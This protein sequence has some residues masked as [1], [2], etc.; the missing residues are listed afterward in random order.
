MS[1]RTSL[2]IC[3]KL[4]DRLRDPRLCLRRTLLR[5][6]M[7]DA[8]A[9]FIECAPT[10]SLSG[11]FSV[12]T[13]LHRQLRSSQT[14]CCSARYARLRGCL[15]HQDTA[16]LFFG[17]PIF[18]R[19]LSALAPF[20]LIVVP[21]SPLRS[22]L[23]GIKGQELLQSILKL[24]K[25]G[26][27]LNSSLRLNLKSKSQRLILEFHDLLIQSANALLN[28]GQNGLHVGEKRS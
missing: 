17:W 18:A 5:T 3:I 2:I 15:L 24:C 26:S 23:V 21:G 4:Y 1:S 22:L 25:M 27:H 9:G 6:S 7:A 20:S 28:R 13:P 19:Y 8:L 10:L 16:S 11:S 12:K 14:R